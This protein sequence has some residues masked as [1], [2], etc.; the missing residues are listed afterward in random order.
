MSESQPLTGGSKKQQQQANNSSSG[1]KS[2]SAVADSAH[3]DADVEAQ[4]GG[5]SNKRGSLNDGRVSPHMSPR[6]AYRWGDV[7]ASKRAHEKKKADTAAIHGQT[8][9]GHA[10]DAGE[11]IKSIVYGGLDGIITTFA[12][13]TSVAGAEFSA[14]VIVVLGI[15]HLFA[16][17]LSMG[18]GD[19]MVS[20][21]VEL[22]WLEGL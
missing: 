6:T 8:E 11:Y 18:M 17:G 22:S 3:H 9:S 19:Y 5:A 4:N 21:R 12:T 10:G 20:R 1:K 14:A 13:V 7:E 16:D 15:S 2:Y